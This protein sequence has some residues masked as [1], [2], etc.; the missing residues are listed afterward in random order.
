MY[1]LLL[2]VVDA[3]LILNERRIKQNRHWVPMHVRL[4]QAHCAAYTYLQV[5]G[6]LS[7]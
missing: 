4:W 6:T 2:Y 7:F 1:N 5:K 3:R